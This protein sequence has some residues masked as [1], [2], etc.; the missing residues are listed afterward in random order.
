[1][2]A[3]TALYSVTCRVLGKYGN[4]NLY[5]VNLSAVVGLSGWLPRSRFGFFLTCTNLHKQ[6]T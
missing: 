4:G 1:M 6:T 5:P 2:G 3:A